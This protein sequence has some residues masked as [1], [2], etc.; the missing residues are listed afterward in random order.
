MLQGRTHGDDCHLMSV[1][2]LATENL[3][4]L[5]FSTLA[6]DTSICRVPQASMLELSSTLPLSLTPHPV[7]Q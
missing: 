7:L 3:A 1:V 2:T 4:L 6:N 5:W